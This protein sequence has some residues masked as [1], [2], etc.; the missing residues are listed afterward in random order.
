[1]LMLWLLPLAQPSAARG[2]GEGE[3]LPW[4]AIWAF[5]LTMMLYVGVENAL[6]GWLPT[7]AQ[8]LRGT[9][10][11]GQGMAGA[12]WGFAEGLTGMAS[13]IALCFW[14]SQLAGRGLMAAF[15]KP[16]Q[17]RRLYRGCLC[18]LL[19]AV[20]VLVA[21]PQ[22]SAQGILLL[23]TVVALSLGPLFPLAVSF[24]LARTGSHPQ[25]GRV[26]ATSSLGGSVL[27]WL[28]GLLSAHFLSLRT[29]FV[30]PGIGAALLLVLSARVTRT[31]PAS[32]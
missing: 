28:T 5:V 11:G 20:L 15:F 12:D 2:S 9:V 19:G 27:P 17:E 26:F 10:P 3:R 25:L 31:A 21:A 4:G 13:S 1:M 23:T 7:Y 6:A 32:R 22:W 18:V 24:L 14:I 29:G 16:G 8:R 30:V